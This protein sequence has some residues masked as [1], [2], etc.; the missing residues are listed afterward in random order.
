M[1]VGLVEFEL[2][3]LFY[4]VKNTAALWQ[5]DPMNNRIVGRPLRLGALQPLALAVGG[6]AV[7]VADYDSGWS[8]G[9]TLCAARDRRA[10]PESLSIGLH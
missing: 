10:I 4:P 7:W 9:S 8:P 2:A 6:G 1:G 3:T 5:I